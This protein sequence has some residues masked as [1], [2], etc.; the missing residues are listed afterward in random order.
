MSATRK[1]PFAIPLLALVAAC[2][3]PEDTL[4]ARP[5]GEVKSAPARAVFVEPDPLAIPAALHCVSEALGGE[6]FRA[7]LGEGPDGPALFVRGG[8]MF[9]T[10]GRS[11]K[12]H[13]ED[14]DIAGGPADVSLVGEALH[15][16]DRGTE[17]S[18]SLALIKSGL[19]FFGE[20]TRDHCYFREARA[21]TC[22]DP[23][24]IFASSWAD[25]IGKLPAAFDWATGACLDAAGAPALNDVPVEFVRETG[26]GACA[27]LRGVRLN[28]DDFDYPQLGWWNLQGAQLDGAQLFFA[29]LVGAA[30]QGTKLDGLQ[31]GYATV[32]G[33]IDAMTTL[34]SESCTVESS[35]WGGDFAQCAR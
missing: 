33:S 10:H 7:T 12:V 30:L 17:E 35:P 5:G 27:D 3:G 28:G 29:D 6:V 24:E 26:F 31:F 23:N 20:L 1:S 18:F 15:I 11:E 22:W 9:Q 4:V 13:D 21:V 14:F 16:I 25:P 8:R 19:F 34:P 2:G 32:A